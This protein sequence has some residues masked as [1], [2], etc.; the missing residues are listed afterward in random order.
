MEQAMPKHFERHTTPAATGGRI[1][2]RSRPR[3]KAP[4][5]VFHV[6][7]PIYLHETVAAFL[8]DLRGL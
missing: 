8:N 1:H 7:V 3:R 6:S 2:W 5:A 4:E